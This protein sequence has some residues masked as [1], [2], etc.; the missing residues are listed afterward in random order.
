MLDWLTTIPG[1][2]I[3]CGVILL[4]IAIVLFI[5]GNKKEKRTNSLAMN[6]GVMN[7]P[8]VNDEVLTKE[9]APMIIDEPKEMNMG[10][11]NPSNPAIADFTQK[12]QVAS[13]P[14]V[15][16][17]EPAAGLYDFNQPTVEPVS[18]QTQPVS[19]N[20]SA[21]DF[22]IHTEIPVVNEQPTVDQ[23][24]QVVNPTIVS[25]PANTFNLGQSI[26]EPAA[27][28]TQ[29]VTENTSAYD[30]SISNVVPTIDEVKPQVE[31]VIPQAPVEEPAASVNTFDFN[32]PTPT[33]VVEEIKPTQPEVTIYGGN[34]PLVNTQVATGQVNHEP[35]MGTP[36]V[37][38]VPPVMQPAVEEP[39]VNIMPTIS[40]PEIQPIETN[41][42]EL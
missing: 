37:T 15:Q 13:E 9:E 26:V 2:L 23:P 16:S 38:V 31:S 10:G 41:K 22:S 25:E 3:A 33:P 21:Y 32:I 7:Q 18:T 8:L 40:I 34:D 12:A 30:F 28:Q 17:V 11:V 20:T 4:L 24:T 6:T 5:I 39:K 27:T 19:E 29:P 35:Y 36:E 42:E 14:V 1:I